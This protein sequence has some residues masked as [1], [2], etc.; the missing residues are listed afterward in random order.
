[1]KEKFLKFMQGRYGADHFNQF[2]AYLNIILIIILLVTKNQILNYVVFAIII[3]STFR[4]LS[5]NIN[6]RY[7]ENQKYLEITSPVRRFFKRTK[8]NVKDKDYKYIKC[9]NCK[10]ELRVPTKK[11]KINVTCKKCGHK[12]QTRT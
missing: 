11:G 4:M 1:M 8:R 10:Q 2:L 3:Y 6:A 5:K 9:E 7:K 12:F